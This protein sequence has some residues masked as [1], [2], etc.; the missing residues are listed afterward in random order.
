[1]LEKMVIKVLNENKDEIVNYINKQVNI[2]LIG[3]EM[4]QKIFDS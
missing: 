2:P 3:E 4:E 1:M